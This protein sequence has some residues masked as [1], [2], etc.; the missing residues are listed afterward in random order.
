MK[1]TIKHSFHS[2]APLLRTSSPS[3]GKGNNC[4]FTLIELLVVVLIIGILAAVAVPQYQVAVA[5]S[6]LA[7][8]KPILKN[9]K[10]GHELY[11][12]EN[13]SYLNYA[14]SIEPLI[15]GTSCT[16]VDDRSVFK[17]DDYFLID[18][19]NSIQDVVA[20]A[21]CPGFQNTWNGT[22]GCSAKSDFTYTIYLDHSTNPGKTICRGKTSLGKSVCKA[23]GL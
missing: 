3:R 14:D 11:Y 13:G 19:I 7:A 15:A 23:E 5:K 16:P 8:L 6:H 2:P 20:A 12:L 18:N 17:C 22:N 1:Y 9:L 10:D 21:Y 4:G